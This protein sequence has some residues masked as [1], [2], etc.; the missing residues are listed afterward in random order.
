MAYKHSIDDDENNDENKGTKSDKNDNDDE[1]KEN[2]ENKLDGTVSS[3]SDKVA[4]DVLNP[5]D[6]E[7]NDSDSSITTDKDEKENKDAEKVDY[8]S[9]NVVLKQGD[10]WRRRINS[11]YLVSWKNKLAMFSKQWFRAI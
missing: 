1:N 8:L 2:K 7:T 4:T 6:D 5:G 3:N 11:F 9:N 10:L